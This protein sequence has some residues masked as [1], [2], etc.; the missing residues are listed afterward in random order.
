[1]RKTFE[2]TTSLL[3]S[4]IIDKAS[5]KGLRVDAEIGAFGFNFR[6]CYVLVCL[7]LVELCEVV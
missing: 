5:E 7:V 3:R 4:A 2:A 6:W 1:M